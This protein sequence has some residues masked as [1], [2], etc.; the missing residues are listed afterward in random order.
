MSLSIFR[1]EKWGG[2]GKAKFFV[3][4]VSFFIAFLWVS[5]PFPRL[6]CKRRCYENVHLTALS[7]CDHKEEEGSGGGA[8]RQTDGMLER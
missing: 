8:A 1:C 2:T 6:K 4:F 3:C 7:G 5:E